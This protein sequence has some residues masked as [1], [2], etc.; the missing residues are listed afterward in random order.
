[1]E[2]LFI[3]RNLIFLPQTE[4][5][6]SYATMLL[7]NVKP[8]EGTVVHTSHQTNG[9]G[10]R[11]NLWITAPHSN[12]TASVILAPFFLEAEKNFLLY[13][14]SALACYDVMSE[15]LN[16]GQI[17]I[18]IKWPNDIL[19]SSRK[20][21]GILIENSITQNRINWSV[22]GIGINVNQLFSNEQL[23]ATSMKQIC[24]KEFLT[25]DVL[26]SLC[27][28]LEKYYLMLKAGKHELVKNL[29][30][31]KLYG[32]NKWLNFEI[33]GKM[34][35]LLVKGVN[36]KGLLILQDSSKIDF[37]FDVKGIKWTY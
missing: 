4:S 25:A 29:Y 33:N 20:I 26:D 28:Y 19:V 34:E 8:V 37:Y 16:D 15:M 10:Q 14:I 11:G 7:K 30:D 17:D 9:R 2:T 36:E 3:G 21:A 23:S 12:L 24:D 6:N 18:K 32:K 13:Q 1:M 35:N 31:E 5:T 27:G 22:I